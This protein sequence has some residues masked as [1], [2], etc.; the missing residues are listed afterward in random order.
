MSD[1]M[2]LRKIRG[3]KRYCDVYGDQNVFGFHSKCNYSQSLF[4]HS[5]PR[6][7]F[8]N[9][10]AGVKAS[11]LLLETEGCFRTASVSK[12]ESCQLLLVWCPY[13][14]ARAWRASR[15]R[16]TTKSL[17]GDRSPQNWYRWANLRVKRFDWLVPFLPPRKC[18]VDA[19]GEFNLLQERRKRFL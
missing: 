8:P 16:A 15:R 1:E 14:S 3:V 9:K 11:A 6:T 5:S 19:D 2:G 17:S 7:S 18:Y 10:A 4:F 12:K 13:G